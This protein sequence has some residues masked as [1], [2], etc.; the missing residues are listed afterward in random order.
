MLILIW[1]KRAMKKLKILLFTF[2]V[3]F[4]GI[5]SVYALNVPKDHLVSPH[6]VYS[7]MHNKNLVIVDVRV[8]KAYASGH[9]PGSVN[10]PFPSIMQ[11][12]IGIK[13]LGNIA[14]PEKMTGI[15]RRAGITNHSIIVFT[16][17]GISKFPLGYSNETRALWT[18]WFYGL[19]KMAILNG[20]LARW[21]KDKLPVTTKPSH[22]VASNFTIMKMRL[23]SRATYQRI[24]K[25]LY[26]HNVVLIDA[27]PV[28][29]FKGLDHDPRFIKHGH[30]PGAINVPFT[31]FEKM[32]KAGY[33]EFVTPAEARAIL[34]KAGVSFRKPII[35]Q[36]NTGY[37][38]SA[39]W[40]VIK[41]LLHKNNVADYNGSWVQYSRI[42]NAPIVD[43]HIHKY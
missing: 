43:L 1:E 41:F 37:W 3:M 10:I 29:W 11:N 8:P 38:A 4:F 20:G 36:C 18:G 15:Y 30:I 27:R 31:E 22:P 5:S 13:I 35:T 42:P 25:Y 12:Y 2:L 21:M 32:S 9:I 28:A 16:G 24:W 39:D 33:Y 19:T 40:F 17:G 23:R 7:H 26:I 6:W 34:V 14:S